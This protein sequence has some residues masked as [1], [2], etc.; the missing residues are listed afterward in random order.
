MFGVPD[1]ACE[2]EILRGVR[3]CFG[4][5]DTHQ[6]VRDCG[7]CIGFRC[8][9]KESS[10]DSV[11]TDA[12]PF[13]AHPWPSVL[14]KCRLKQLLNYQKKRSNPLD[15]FPVRPISNRASREG[16]WRVLT[17]RL[18]AA[19]WFAPEMGDVADETANISGP[20]QPFPFPWRAS[21][22]NLIFH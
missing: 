3:R 8:R 10:R 9:R 16:R 7:L 1:L 4:P 12:A 2:P 5:L 6:G 11:P 15:S 21:W 20:R 18:T 17:N 13:D 19:R 22:P 14:W